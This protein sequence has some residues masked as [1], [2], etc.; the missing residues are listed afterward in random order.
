M[1][2]PGEIA[3]HPDLELVRRG[4]SPLPGWALVREAILRASGGQEAVDRWRAANPK[5]ADHEDR[6][7]EIASERTAALESKRSDVQS[8]GPATSE[9]IARLMRAAGAHPEDVE[10]WLRKRPLDTPAAGFAREW[11]GEMN[12]PDAPRVLVLTGGTGAGKTLAGLGVLAWGV[13]QPRRRSGWPAARWFALPELLPLGEYERPGRDRWD[14]AMHSW[15]V[16]LDDLGSGTWNEYQ[17][18]RFEA[19]LEHR[20]SSGLP[21][22]VTTNLSPRMV[23]DDPKELGQRV[24]SRMSGPRARVAECGSRDRR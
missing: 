16:V 13:Q 4:L 14:E 9:E 11:I 8:R 24:N 19:L 5:Q 18:R 1:K 21:T 10:E 12:R 6:A 15:L 22:V 20:M 3:E 7:R 17:R 23:Q 2:K